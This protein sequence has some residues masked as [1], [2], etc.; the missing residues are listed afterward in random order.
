[1]ITID[2][3]VRFINIEGKIMKSRYFLYSFVF[4]IVA[5]FLMPGCAWL[6]GYGKVRL[7]T[8]Y[9]DD[10][11]IQ[12]LQE[13]WNDYNISYAGM[14]PSNPAGIMFDRK[15]DGREL[16]GDRW[17]RVE[18]KETVSEITSWI[19]TYTQFHPRLHVILAPNNKLYGYIFYPWGYDYVVTKVINDKTLYVY[20]LESPVYLNDPSDEWWE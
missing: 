1:M 3:G 11:T 9:G 14:S 16:V 12:K 7:S 8:E 5:A 20:D 4:I 15:N 10:M 6:R 18:E 19:E 13:N 17:I 2:Y